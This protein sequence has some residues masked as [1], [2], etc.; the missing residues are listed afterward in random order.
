[1]SGHRLTD[2]ERR[3]FQRNRLPQIENAHA[4]QVR[5]LEQASDEIYERG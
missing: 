2:E 5:Q 4:G 3:T 1:V